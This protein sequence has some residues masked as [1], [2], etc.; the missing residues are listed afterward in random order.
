MHWAMTVVLRCKQTSEKC[1][2]AML[3]CRDSLLFEIDSVVFYKYT[4]VNCALSTVF[5]AGCTEQCA[6]QGGVYCALCS[7]HWAL[8]K[9][10]CVPFTAHFVVCTEHWAVWKGGTGTNVHPAASPGHMTHPRIRYV[11]IFSPKLE[12]YN[13]SRYIQEFEVQEVRY[14]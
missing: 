12:M 4:S 3:L 7:V 6:P 13:I 1:I 10:Q 14:G 9:R 8:W 2:Y 11:W 5:F